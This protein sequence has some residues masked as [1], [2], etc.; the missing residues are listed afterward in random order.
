MILLI[1]KAREMCE[2]SLSARLAAVNEHQTNDREKKLD[3][4]QQS[5]LLEA[6]HLLQTGAGLN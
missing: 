4:K 5:G 3:M 6:E 1:V 2:C